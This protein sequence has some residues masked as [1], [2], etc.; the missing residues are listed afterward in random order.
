M[1]A[2][3]GLEERGLVQPDRAG[4]PAMEAE[5]AAVFATRPRD[6]WAEIFA[7]TDAC[8]TPVLSLHEAIDHRQAT[9]RSSFTVR[10]GI[11]QAA[12]APRFS[13]TPAM[14]GSGGETELSAA[15][16]RWTHRS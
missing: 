13:A 15:I 12:P 8:V 6:E 7:G 5:L 16:E 3:L 2:G 1:I 9:E 10:H 14:I 4:W 11:A